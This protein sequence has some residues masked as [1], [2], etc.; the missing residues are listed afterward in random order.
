MDQQTFQ[1]ESVGKSDA[2]TVQ[3]WIESMENGNSPDRLTVLDQVIDGSIGG[4]GNRLEYILHTTRAVPLFEFRNLRAI[5]TGDIPGMVNDAEQEVMQYHNEYAKSPR[6]IRRR[7]NTRYPFV[8]RQN[9]SDACL[10]ANSGAT[11]AYST[12]TATYKTGARTTKAPPATTAGPSMPSCTL[13]NQD[14][15]QGIN[16]QGCICGSTTLPLLMVASPT[17][18]SQSCAYTAMPSSSVSNPISRQQQ[19]WTSK[20]QACT[21][22]G[23]IADTP[24]CTSV[25]GCTATTSANPT[26]TLKVFLSNNSV[27]LGDENS[28]N[29][30]TDLR[31]A[32]YTKL[33][34]LCPDTADECNSSK[35]DAEIDKIASLTPDARPDKGKLNFTISDSNYNSPKERDQMLAAAVAFWQQAAEKSCQSVPYGG[36]PAKAHSV[37]CGTGPVKRDLAFTDAALGKRSPQHRP[38]CTL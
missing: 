33:Q 24:T 12:G 4:L 1:V 14:P 5:N 16:A 19:V 11:V 22:V 23:G 28:K 26:P 37:M 38:P 21:L 3:D 30:G 13:R 9:V 34:A 6:F 2:C 35:G 18:D 36:Q 15:D 25:G 17:N 10:P 32:M 31:N 7:L 8:K 20:C 27:P 29:N